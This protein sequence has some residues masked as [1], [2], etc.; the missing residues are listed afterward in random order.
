MV[1]SPFK[2]IA[3][4]KAAGEEE[5]RNAGPSTGLRLQKLA[6]LRLIHKRLSAAADPKN[7]TF[8][9]DFFHLKNNFMSLKFLPFLG[10]CGGDVTTNLFFS[11]IYFH[12]QKI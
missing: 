9:T 8:K 11:F 4:E 3:A 12:S 5:K 10:V 6:F 7:K 1:C 2:M